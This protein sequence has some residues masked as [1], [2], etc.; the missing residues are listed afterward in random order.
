MS[1][2]ESYD[3]TIEEAAELHKEALMA[4]EEA[5]ELRGLSSATRPRTKKGYFD[6]HMPTNIHNAPMSEVKEVLVHMTAFADYAQDLSEQAKRE[7]DHAESYLK[8]VKSKIRKTKV[9]SKSDQDDHT[10]TD[11][12]F[13]SAN[14][15]YLSKLHAYEAIV[16]RA[17]AARR[18]IRT[19]S[20]LVSVEQVNNDTAKQAAFAQ[21]T[22]KGRKRWK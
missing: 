20:R 15:E 14:A 12:R 8:V 9:G 3:I 7:K 1:K 21:S 10:I 22:P 11:I 17:E 5:L 13:V 16:A 2:K 4:T 19:L 6:G 18:G